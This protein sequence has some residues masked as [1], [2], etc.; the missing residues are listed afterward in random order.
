MESKLI[1]F[2]DLFGLKN[3]KENYSINDKNDIKKEKEIQK[4]NILFEKESS[5]EI[6]KEKN[7]IHKN[8]KLIFL[9]HKRPHSLDN[10]KENIL[11]QAAKNKKHSRNEKDNILTKIQIHYRNFL[12]DFINEVIKKIIIDECYKTKQLDKIIHLKKY[13]FNKID[14]KFKSN[15]KKENMKLVENIKIKN[16]IS[17][18]VSFCKKY[19]IKNKNQIIMERI[20]S[21]NNPILNLIL[22]SDYLYFFDLY[23]NSQRTISLKEDDFNIELELNQGIKLFNDLIEKNKSDENYLY[24]L[25]KFAS[26]NFS[27]TKK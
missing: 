7:V 19:N 15:I 8:K 11:N 26:L 21:F 4:Q 2:P 20:K 16:L 14:H 25:K 18:S 17:P 13:L 5:K 6:L 24:N 23:Y 1:N 27:K 12:V 10:D 9:V 22:D 3:F